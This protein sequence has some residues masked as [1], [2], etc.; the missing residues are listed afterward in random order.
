MGEDRDGLPGREVWLL[1]RHLLKDPADL[2]Y[3]L[4]HAPLKTPLSKLAQVAASRY[5]VEQCIDEAKGETSLA[6][7]E[8]RY[9]YSWY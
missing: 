6:D 7:Y 4:C 2:A 1:A 8:I 3:Y 5:T 9:W